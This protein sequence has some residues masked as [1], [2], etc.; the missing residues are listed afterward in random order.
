MTTVDSGLGFELSVELSAVIVAV[1]SSLLMFAV[2]LLL[3]RDPGTSAFE[4][5]VTGFVV[6]ITYYLGLRFSG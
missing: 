2:F 3:G 6:G 4:V 1:V 5:I